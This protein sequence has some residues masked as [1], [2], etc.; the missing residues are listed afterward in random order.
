[1]SRPSARLPELDLLRFIAAS[2]VV[3]YHF[4]YTP[5]VAGVVNT[6]IFGS[7]HD[8]ARYGY[9]GVDLFF[10]ISGFVILMTAAR[11]SPRGFLVH[12]ALRLYPSFWVAVGLTVTV[13]TLLGRSAL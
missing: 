7:V 9:V 3:I 2:T 6:T 8:L 12:R 10:V 1:M 11:R 4:C 5:V 13:V